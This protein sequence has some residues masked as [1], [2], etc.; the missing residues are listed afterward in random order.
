[1]SRIPPLSL[2]IFLLIFFNSVKPNFGNSRNFKLLKVL[3]FL[4]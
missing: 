4:I 2:N 1:M 3:N